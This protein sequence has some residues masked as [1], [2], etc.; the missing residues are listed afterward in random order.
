MTHHEAA[1]T[2]QLQPINIMKKKNNRAATTVKFLVTAGQSSAAE[3][4]AT[5]PHLV[6]AM[7]PQANAKNYA[8]GSTLAVV[9]KVASL[10][11]EGEHGH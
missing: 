5:R 1:R 10:L 7:R 3:M 8:T 9:E 6:V 11:E 2:T 4:K